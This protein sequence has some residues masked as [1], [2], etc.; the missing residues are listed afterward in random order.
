MWV[1]LEGRDVVATFRTGNGKGLCAEDA[2]EKMQRFAE[3]RLR[4]RDRER[5]GAAMG[6]PCLLTELQYV[7]VR[8]RTVIAG[9]GQ[10]KE[11]DFFD[12]YE[13]VRKQGT[14][15]LWQFGT[16]SAMTGSGTMARRKSKSK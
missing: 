11:R 3:E 4:A 6:V 10:G 7:R 15:A 8:F 14:C 5:R 2:E 16:R 1:V 12:V 13:K 9:F